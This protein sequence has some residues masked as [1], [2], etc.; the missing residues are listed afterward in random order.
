MTEREKNSAEKG[1]GDKKKKS[2]GLFGI[3]K[4][5]LL[6]VVIATVIQAGFQF[7]L[8]SG[9][10]EQNVLLQNLIYNLG[11]ILV[12][13][14]FV[15]AFGYIYYKKLE[16]VSE[17]IEKLAEGKEV[18]MPETGFTAELMQSINKTSDM[19]K[20]QRDVIAKRDNAR[21]EWIRGVSH[22]IRTPLSI[23]MGYSEALEEGEIPGESRQKT[24]E[25]IKEQSIKIRDLI[26]DLNLA[27]K[28][29]Y[30]KQPLR[31]SEFYLS[32][33]LRESVGGLM[34]SAGM[35]SEREQE[36]EPYDIELVVLPEFEKLMLSGDRMLI[37]RVL[38]NILGNA[39]RHNP[40]GCRVLCL[41]YKTAE[42][43]VVEITDDGKGIPEDIASAINSFQSELKRNGSNNGEE[44][45]KSEPGEDTEGD[46]D[47]ISGKHIMGLRIAKQIMLAHGG[48][49]IIKP[50]RHTVSLI[51]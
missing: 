3:Y 50:D 39:V 19:L 23:I 37:K 38:D 33:L 11:N 7:A 4:T 51:F 20:A 6:C 29:E 8:M 13:L 48:N 12:I 26:E 41:A 16:E 35:E 31:I 44:Y 14:A 43:A 47:R 10:R 9:V 1:R 40:S 36:D 21:A 42:F 15:A 46:T 27:M 34:D 17:S 22:D 49:L 24:A 18:H 32:A 30:G 5:F 28:L 25:I 2:G 45:L